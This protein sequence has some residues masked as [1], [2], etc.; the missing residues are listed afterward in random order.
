MTG[1]TAI[2]QSSTQEAAPA[3]R[4]GRR[5]RN[6]L[7]KRARIVA[8][9]RRLFDRQGFAETTTLQIAEA[10]DIGTGTLFLY[11]RSKEDLLVMVFKDEMMEVALNLFQRLPKAGN[12]VDQALAVF[13]GMVDYHARDID[14]TR[15]LMRE[16]IIPSEPDRRSA[17]DDLTAV[18]FGN[19]ASLVESARTKGQ[20]DQRFN[21]EVTGRTIFAIYYF[22]LLS[23]LA[24]RLD[25]KEML[26]RLER[27][28]EAF[29]GIDQS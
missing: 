15:L 12:L 3:P 4:L 29:L 14:L 16:I 27:E 20:I 26:V 17:M 28:L 5:E 25:R 9:A 19:L 24:G 2:R 18:I 6:K 10:A 8:A 21:P 1:T 22:N 23:W 13:A 11:A 7:E